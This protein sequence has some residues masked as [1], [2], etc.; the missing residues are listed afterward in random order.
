M[1]NCETIPLRDLITGKYQLR[2][3]LNEEVIEHYAEMMA[4]SWGNFPPIDVAEISG[5][6][7]IVDGHHRWAAAERAGIGAVPFQIVA[8]TENQAWMESYRRNATQGLCFTRADRQNAIR[9]FCEQMPNAS[10]GFIASLIGCDPETVRRHRPTPA[11][12][13]VEKRVG[14][15]GKARKTSTPAN[16]A[17]E[18]E[19]EDGEDGLEDLLTGDLPVDSLDLPD[20][21]KTRTATPE[22]VACE[23]CGTQSTRDFAENA[24]DTT[25]FRANGLWFC[26]DA[27]QT[28]YGTRMYYAS[29]YTQLARELDQLNQLLADW[30]AKI[31]QPD[32]GSLKLLSDINLHVSHITSRLPELRRQFHIKPEVQP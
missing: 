22:L 14:L 7:Y 16:A 31:P 20:R 23:Y 19:A 26:C 24:A 5:K 18:T 2:L 28:A 3:A 17:V 12:A 6:Y 1:E 9:V 15:D 32:T 11:N 10:N 8:T 27:C 25:W 13:A 4:G 21:P 30:M 29:R